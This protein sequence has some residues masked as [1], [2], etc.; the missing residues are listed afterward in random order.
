MKTFS[1]F[2]EEAHLYEMRKEDKV[3][4]KKPTPLLIPHTRVYKQKGFIRKSQE[5]KWVVTPA[6]TSTH[7]QLVGNPAVS[8]G[9]YRQGAIGTGGRENLRYKRHA[10]GGG[11]GYEAPGELRGVGKVPGEKKPEIGHQTPAEKV[12]ERKAKKA[13]EQRR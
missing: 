8:A 13:Q 11:A 4:G 3:A 7:T 9:R 12:A 10:H 1:E 2:L 5:G 6:R